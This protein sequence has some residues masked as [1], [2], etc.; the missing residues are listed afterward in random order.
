MHVW[1][2]RCLYGHLNSKWVVRDPKSAS[3]IVD[4]YFGLPE[5]HNPN[6]GILSP[7]NPFAEMIFFWVL[8]LKKMSN[9][10]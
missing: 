4:T 1:E 8:S 3:N 6:M 2:I 10:Y 5:R 7:E 9:R